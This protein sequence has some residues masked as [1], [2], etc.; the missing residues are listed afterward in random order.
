MC[1]HGS[2]S[3]MGEPATVEMTVV[4]DKGANLGCYGNE[5][6]DTEESIQT[7]GEAGI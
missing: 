2:F 1:S 5:S 7:A 3:L 6:R 4:C